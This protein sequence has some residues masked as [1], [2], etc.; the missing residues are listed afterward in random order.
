MLC[1]YDQGDKPQTSQVLN[2]L[3]HQ[4]TVKNSTR[5]LLKN[6]TKYDKIKC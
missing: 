2:E 5:K 3:T 1:R 6:T 4:L